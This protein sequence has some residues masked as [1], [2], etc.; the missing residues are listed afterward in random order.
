[1]DFG[2]IQ[3]DSKYI[4]QLLG[5]FVAIGSIIHKLTPN[6]LTIFA[7]LDGD[8]PN[9]ESKNVHDNDG[10]SVP[11]TI[12]GLLA[13][14]TKFFDAVVYLGIAKNRRPKPV[15]TQRVPTYVDMSKLAT[16]LFAAF[17]YVLIRARPPSDCDAY[18][19]QPMPR[20]ITTVIKCKATSSQIIEYLSSF[21]LIKLGPKWVKYIPTSIREDT[22][23]RLGLVVAGYRLVSVFNQV[24]PDL[25]TSTTQKHQK[26]KQKTKPKYLDRAIEVA[27]SFKTAGYCWDFHPATRSPDLISKYGN[28]NKNATN[29]MLESYTTETL[30]KLVETNRLPAKP[31]FDP[32]HTEYRTWTLDMK[33]I[34]TAKIFT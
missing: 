9:K 29:L 27:K 23:N 18:R 6:D 17:F 25:Y 10:K 3:V 19:N 5:K 24:Q 11:N 4:G 26:Y 2:V 7:N 13:N 20:F 16:Y 32:A 14:G 30:V 15:I 33:Y 31:I 8:Y 34:A 1:M 22:V 28:I 12:D 21:D